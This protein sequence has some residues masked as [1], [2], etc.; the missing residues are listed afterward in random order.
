M[1]INE[2]YSNFYFSM[3]YNNF[4]L[5]KYSFKSNL[6]DLRIFLNFFFIINKF[7]LNKKN[8]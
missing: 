2:F 7:S 6:E 5:F 3:I 1:L 4:F 8:F